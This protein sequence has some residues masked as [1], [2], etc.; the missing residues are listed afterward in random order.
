MD[1][2]LVGSLLQLKLQDEL[3]EAFKHLSSVVT[4]I[5]KCQDYPENRLKKVEPETLA[6]GYN[7]HLGSNNLQFRVLLQD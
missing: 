4:L 6:N 2:K 1:L 3:L 7:V 5:C